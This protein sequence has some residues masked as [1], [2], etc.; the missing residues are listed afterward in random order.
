[1]SHVVILTLGTRGDLEP[2]T[3]LANELAMEPSVGAVTIAAP[4][5][6]ICHYDDISGVEGKVASVRY[7][8][9]Y[10]AEAKE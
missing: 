1:M 10:T 5:L 2:F 3:V 4:Q 8:G 9:I 7:V 6:E